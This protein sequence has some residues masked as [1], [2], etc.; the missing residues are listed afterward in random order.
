MMKE[1]IAAMPESLR[2][3]SRW[4]Y[5]AARTAEKQHQN[6]AARTQYTDLLP[7]DNYFAVLAAFAAFVI[8]RR[9]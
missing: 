8:G 9:P 7:T 4:R 6:E 3:Q 1:A 2:N 5:W